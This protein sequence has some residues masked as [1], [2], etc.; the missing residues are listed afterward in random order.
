MKLVEFRCEYNGVWIIYINA[1]FY[2]C[3]V[4]SGWVLK[5]STRE[6][7]FTISAVVTSTGIQ[8]QFLRLI[9]HPNT[10]TWRFTH[11]YTTGRVQLRRNRHWTTSVGIMT[12]LT[13]ACSSHPPFIDCPSVRPK[14][15]S[16]ICSSVEFPTWNAKS[17]FL[18]NDCVQLL[19]C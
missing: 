13:R 14:V 7:L 19:I 6:P 9:R 4:I 1:R 11:V 5:W 15:V 18:S 10:T 16:Y 3:E 8:N 12:R 17:A 2:L